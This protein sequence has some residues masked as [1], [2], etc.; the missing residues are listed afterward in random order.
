ML[1]QSQGQMEIMVKV[2]EN[3]TSDTVQDFLVKVKP[4]SRPRSL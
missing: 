2:I 1:M 4:K 3:V